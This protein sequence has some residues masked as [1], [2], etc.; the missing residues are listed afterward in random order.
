LLRGT[1]DIDADNIYLLGHSLGG[2]LA[3]RIGVQDEGIAGLIIAAGNTRQLAAMMLEQYD[4][5]FNLDGEISDEEAAALVEVEAGL[6]AIDA[7]TAE[8]DPTEIVL[9]AAPAYWLDLRNYDPVVTAQACP[10]PMLILQGERDYQVTL[11]D[12]AGWQAGLSDRDDVT[13]ITYPALNHLFMAGEGAPNNVEYFTPGFVD[14][15]VIADVAGW[16]LDNAAD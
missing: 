15:Q 2:L 3:P 7:M 12:L 11:E 5:L 1:E 16:V 8:S 10:N 6:A 9:G 13:F 14:A 4:Y